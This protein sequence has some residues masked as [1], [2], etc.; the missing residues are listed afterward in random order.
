MRL[1]TNKVRLVG[2]TSGGQRP[3]PGNRWKQLDSEWA[4]SGWREGGRFEVHSGGLTVTDLM[5]CIR[6]RKHK[7]DDWV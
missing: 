2:R 7:A 6:E 3:A 1:G 4:N 5:Q